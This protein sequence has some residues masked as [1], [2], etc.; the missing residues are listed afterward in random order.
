M[1]RFGNQRRAQAA[2]NGCEEGFAAEH[3]NAPPASNRCRRLSAAGVC[4]KASIVLFPK[5]PVLS[6][7]QTR[8]PHKHASSD[9]N[10]FETEGKEG[11]GES[12]IIHLLFVRGFFQK[13]LESDFVSRFIQGLLQTLP[14]RLQLRWTMRIRQRRR[15]K[16]LPM[17]ATNYISQRDL[18]S[19]ASEKISALLAALAF[20]D[21][22]RFQLD[23][24]LHQVIRRDIL[25]FRERFNT[26]RVTALTQPRQTQHR[27]RGVI[28]FDR[29]FHRPNLRAD[30]A[31]A[32]TTNYLAA[33]SSS[34]TRPSKS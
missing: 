17:H 27:P 2:K 7:V 11:H 29:K 32:Q 24:N 15:I 28:A 26:H 34:T 10:Q 3:D 6:G 31:A 14:C 8:T 13:L 12:D 30:P 33:N 20:H 22:R 19:R 21:L 4:R 5:I 16:N 23:Q 9:G 25:A 18:I 1:V